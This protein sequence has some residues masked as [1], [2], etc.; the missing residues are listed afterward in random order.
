MKNENLTEMKNS[1]DELKNS[2]DELKNSLDELKNSL[3]NTEKI[4]HRI[5]NIIT[6]LRDNSLKEIKNKWINE[7]KS[8]RFYFYQA[9]HNVELILEKME[10][11]FKNSE[12][13][14]DDREM[15]DDSLLLLHHIV[16]I[17]KITV[18]ESSEIN[19][20]TVDQILT[21]TYE[22]RNEA[23]STNLIG[24]LEVNPENL[25]KDKLQK[26]FSVLMKKAYA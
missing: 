8:D 20:E 5:L 10:V 7:E 21:E 23:E 15:I 26:L 11:R 6:T 24:I 25:D 19:M 2:L 12:K 16:D 9:V 1:L 18:I 4:D 13:P 22:L 14:N 3:D 17:L